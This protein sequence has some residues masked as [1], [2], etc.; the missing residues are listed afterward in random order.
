MT[1]A[2][3]NV[4]AL[5]NSPP[6]DGTYTISAED[7]KALV[8]QVDKQ[9]AQLLSISRA[10][11]AARNELVGAIEKIA[12][13]INED[14]AKAVAANEEAQKAIEEVASFESSF[15]KSVENLRAHNEKKKASG[16]S[17]DLAASCMIIF[18]AIMAGL[19]VYVFYKSPN[20]NSISPMKRIS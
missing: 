18:A 20:H 1:A 13:A 9:R 16:K 4:R 7:L 15:S 19:C 17:K 12:K 3:D 6:Q 2:L 10:P 11:G 14:T 8:E 5:L